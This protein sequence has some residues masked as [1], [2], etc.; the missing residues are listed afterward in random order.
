MM[1]MDTLNLSATALKPVCNFCQKSIRKVLPIQVNGEVKFINVHKKC[2][3]KE[4]KFRKKEN[5][6][7]IRIVKDKILELEFQLFF[8]TTSPYV[9]K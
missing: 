5:D 3:S 1:D 9:E 7:K 6:D 8:L 2:H 4:V